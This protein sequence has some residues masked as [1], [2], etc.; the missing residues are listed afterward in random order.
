M[1]GRRYLT[2]EQARATY[3]R[4]GRLQDTQGF[5]ERTAVDR[6]VAAGDFASA[7][8]VVEVGCGTGALARRLLVDDLPPQAQYCGLDLS[9]TMVE[10]TRRRLASWADRAEVRLVDGSS[11]WPVEDGVVDRVVATYVLDLLSPAA[12]RAFWEQAARVLTPSG[13]V[14]LTSLTP[15]TGALTRLVSGAWSSL[16]RVNPRLTAGCRPV[17]LRDSLPAGWTVRA[18]ETV[19]ALG[20]SSQVLV[21]GRD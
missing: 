6:M 10:L 2:P 3:D 18:L 15:G 9:P 7:R 20:V 4:I 13:T 5:Y 11:P 12:T 16:W 19:G 21:A 1:A 14:C 8:S 17:D